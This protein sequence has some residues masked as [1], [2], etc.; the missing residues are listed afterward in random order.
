V[1]VGVSVGTDVGF[2]VGIDRGVAVGAAV[3]ADVGVAVGVAVVVPDST[4]LADITL[5]PDT[6]AKLPPAAAS[7][8]VKP[9][10]A[11]EV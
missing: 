3:G 4:E 7:S 10:L 6:E 2:A 1:S 9:E 11:I 5:T 8:V